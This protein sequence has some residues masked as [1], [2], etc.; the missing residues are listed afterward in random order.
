MSRELLTTKMKHP[1]KSIE[2]IN[3]EIAEIIN[4]NH[5]YGN[6]F[7][8]VILIKGDDLPFQDILSRE[9]IEAI[10]T[11]FDNLLQEPIGLDGTHKE[12]AR[13]PVGIYQL[14]TS[15]GKSYMQV[16]YSEDK[17]TFAKDFGENMDLQ[18][19]TVEEAKAYI[20]QLKGIQYDT[21]QKKEMQKKAI[22]K[23]QDYINERKKEKIANQ[24]GK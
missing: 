8:E 2:E 16:T 18:F 9:R 3:H 22:K 11:E 13:K 5:R 15:E 10:M 4:G 21:D 14:K 17:M 23:A 19:A 12:K 1:V 24:Q 6:L 20:E 7:L